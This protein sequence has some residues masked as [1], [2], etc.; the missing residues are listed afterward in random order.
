MRKLAVLV[1]VPLFA[2]A[3]E[4]APPGSLP[5]ST[6]RNPAFIGVA[7]GAARSNV[8]GQG[9]ARLLSL[10]AGMTVTPR[11]LC[12]FGISRLTSSGPSPFGAT[13]SLAISNLDLIF[14]F[15]PMERG[16]FLRGGVGRSLLTITEEGPTLG[17][18]YSREASTSGFEV[19]GG[20]GYAFSLGHF[21]LAVAVDAT[22]QHWG[23]T[24]PST[25][26]IARVGA[27]WY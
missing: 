24:G 27:G 4:G 19:V 5:P 14:S 10:E 17:G 6:Q 12:G 25:F 9:T 16:L 8:S 22:R 20:L 1:V 18:T 7:V 23:A 13:T 3:Q 15:F 21:D 2:A 26:L 11:L